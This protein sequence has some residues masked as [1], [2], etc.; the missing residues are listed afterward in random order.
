MPDLT[1]SVRFYF[2]PRQGE[3]AGIT[4]TK[5]D[6]LPDGDF[7][8]TEYCWGDASLWFL[9][10]DEFTADERQEAYLAAAR[11]GETP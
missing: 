10:A 7:G 4:V 9:D 5:R 1:E 8:I 11:Q 6:S 2:W 3:P